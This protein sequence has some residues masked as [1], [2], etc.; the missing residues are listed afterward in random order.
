MSY[1]SLSI[2]GG[3]GN[4]HMNRFRICVKP[5]RNR[6]DVATIGSNLLV[7]MGRYMAA[8]SAS[9]QFGDY[10]WGQ[11]PTLKF[12]GVARLRPFSV[13]VQVPIGGI[14]IWIPVPKA[15]RDWMAPDVHTDSVGVVARHGTGFTVQT[16]KREY[17][18]SDD[19]TIRAAIKTLVMSGAIVVPAAIPAASML[20]DALGGLA[21]HYNQ[22]H[23]LAGRRGFRF[24]WGMNFGYRDDRC[25]FETV[26]IE[27]FSSA[28]FQGSVIAM[29]DVESL[30]RDVWVEMLTRFCTLHRL[31]VIRGERPG[32]GWFKSGEVHCMQTEVAD[33]VT[34]IEGSAHFNTMK[35]EHQQILEPR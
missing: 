1:T 30:V 6:N 11:D 26:A 24:D 12:R 8:T 21:V 14:P 34:A 4:V 9:V 18:D 25:V 29:G 13:P 7:N 10:N 20:A 23:F 3:Y 22:H 19:A 15:V 16:L 28:V 17:E 35:A 33:R 32:T 27:R 31:E 2:H 5:P